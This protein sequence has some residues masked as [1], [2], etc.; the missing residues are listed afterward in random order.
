LYGVF[1]DLKVKRLKNRSKCPK[2]VK[3]FVY[4]NRVVTCLVAFGQTL[5]AV[6]FMNFYRII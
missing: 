1:L 3:Q 4:K 2:N 6:I 5:S